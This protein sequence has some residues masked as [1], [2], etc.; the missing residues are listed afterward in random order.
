MKKTIKSVV[1]AIFLIAAFP[2]ALLAGFG[3]AEA[4]FQFFA[5]WCALAPGLPGDYL[6]VAY[7]KLTLEACHR[8]VRIQFLS[9]FAHP[10]ASVAR[11]VFI[12]GSCTLGRVSI[13]ERTHIASGVQ[14]AS[15]RR[16]HARD[17][18]G[19]IQGAEDA[20]FEQVKIGSDCWI[21]AGAIVMSDVG[22]GST[23]GA[24]SVVVHP[25]PANSVAV[26]SPARVVA[27]TGG[28]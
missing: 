22:G 18:R 14:I 25:I 28:D 19:Q 13:G 15:G 7:Y 20:A 11:G 17:E 8:D 10:Q 2:M 6:R 3:R 1:Q 16:Q 27:G 24:G 21:G 5:Q 26:G 23:V 12:G 4:I 9:I